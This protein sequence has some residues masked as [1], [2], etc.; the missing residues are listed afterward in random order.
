MASPDTYPYS[1]TAMPHVTIYIKTYCPFCYQAKALLD[2][3]GVKYEEIDV[4]HDPVRETEMQTRSGRD[5]VPQIFIGLHHVGG[6]DDLHD[7]ES[8]GE[9]DRLL[10]SS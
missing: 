2:R 7:A 3:K 9:L 5:T 10:A 8:S 1:A 4:T 6:C